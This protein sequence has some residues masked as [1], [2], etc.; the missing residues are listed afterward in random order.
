MTDSATRASRFVFLAL[1]EASPV[2]TRIRSPSRST[3]AGPTW[4]GPGGTR[5]AGWGKFAPRPGALSRWGTFAATGPP[6][7]LERH[8]QRPEPAQRRRFSP[9]RR[10]VDRQAWPL[11]EEGAQGDLPF[12]PSQGRAETEVDA[13]AEG[14]VPVVSTR[15]IQTVRVRE[16]CRVAVGR[17]DRGHDHRALRERAAVDLDVGGRDARRPLHRAV[18]PQQL[19]HRA[20]NQRRIVPQTPELVR[21][22]Q[23]G[24]QPVADQ[25][26]GRLM[27]GDEEQDAG[28]EQLP[29]A[30]RVAGF[31]GGDQ[32]AQEIVLR[33]PA[34]LG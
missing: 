18:V 26:D 8:R 20:L 23:E 16:V 33:T 12:E 10:R 22:A 32:Q 25:V 17:A 31:L 11:A 5:V 30:Q 4:G 3:P 29:F 15:D 7:P 1:S 19:L 27:A 34:P 14:D 2:Q 13:K 21:M 6:P 24:Q 9:G 28:G